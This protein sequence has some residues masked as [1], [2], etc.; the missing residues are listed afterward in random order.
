MTDGQNDPLEE[1]GLLGEEIESIGEEE[2][3]DLE[4]IS[5]FDFAETSLAPTDWTVETILSQL[6]DTAL[7]LNPDFQRRDAWT[8]ARK[9]K[10]IESLMLGLPVPQLVL[11]EEDPDD[12][13][14]IVIDGKQRLITLEKFFDD[15][16]GFK[17]V[18]LSALEHL[19]GLTCTQ[20]SEDPVHKKY[21][22]RL[23]NRT[24]RTVV[25]RKWPSNSFLHLVFH[26]LNHQTLPLSPQELRQALSP[27]RFTTFA[28]RYAAESRQINSLLGISK[29][30]FRMRDVELLVRFIAFRFR[31]AEY[32]GNLKKFLDDACEVLNGDWITKKDE[33]E[34]A[35]ASC[36]NAIDIT[37]EI[38]DKD[39]FHRYTAG[40]YERRF[41]R[42]VFDIMAF[43][44]S[45]S[46]IASAA[47][48]RR[49]AVKREFERLS[50]ED[51]D[52]ADSLKSTTKTLDATSRRFRVWGEALSRVLD[53][54]FPIPHLEGKR[55]SYP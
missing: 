24:I 9:S 3:S 49:V 7:D 25:I 45:S 40:G 23:K 43:Y 37:R 32:S 46:E 22:R 53:Q 13:T 54:S 5:E 14:Y 41:N 31:I 55:I 2:D 42:T 39:A 15:K 26:R 16:E 19:N 35:A 27:G 29:A 21:V 17:L 8:V 6:K 51:S 28:D 38:F 33:V 52:F 4:G 47:L 44:F 30:D 48:D 18:G 34:A 1:A 50:L 36:D 20:L 11:A 12:G 10:F